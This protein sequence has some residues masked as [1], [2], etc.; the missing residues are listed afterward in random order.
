MRDPQ[1]ALQALAEECLVRVGHDL[2]G[3]PRSGGSG[4]WV[5][6][7]TVLTCAHVVPEGMNATVDLIWQGHRVRGVVVE[8]AGT[9]A[10]IWTYP[11]LAV[12]R[13][14]DTV[15]QHPCVWLAETQP[16]MEAALLVIGHSDPL[17][18]GFQPTSVQGHLRGKVA[19]G[20]GWLWQF[21]SN[22]MRSGM[23]GGPI[24][25]LAAGAVCAL[26]KTTLGEETDR[27]GYVVPLSA[28]NRLSPAARARIL[29]ASDRYHR[30]DQRWVK[31]RSRLPHP[32]D[33]APTML[34][35]EEEVE[36]FGILAEVE[37]PIEELGELYARCTANTRSSSVRLDCLRDVAVALID[38]GEIFPLFQ[39]CEAFA[40]NTDLRDWATALAGRCQAT[41]E[42]R[43]IRSSPARG[44]NGVAVTVEIAPGFTRVDLYRVSVT[45]HHPGGQS[46]LIYCDD[47]AR[48]TLA[49]AKE[50][51]LAELRLALSW[52]RSDAEVEFAVPAGLFDEPFEELSPIRP[53]TNLGRSFRVVLRDVE[54]QSDPFTREEWTRRWRSLAGGSAGLHWMSCLDDRTVT[55][56]AADLERSSDVALLMLSRRPSSCVAISDLVKV[57]LEFGVPALAWRR[58]TCYEHDQGAAIDTCSGGDFRL[59][60][61]PIL[62]KRSLSSLPATVQEIRQETARQEPDPEFDA[63]RNMV[64]VWDNPDRL[65]QQ[66]PLSEPTIRQREETL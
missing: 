64:L 15:P 41:T 4:V 54:R 61:E 46:R 27:G 55:E 19:F 58:D 56:F 51:I 42:L 12:I 14:S 16:P 52:L 18:E 23:S 8:H 35:Y 24:L 3:A 53:Y 20:D 30:S 32:P 6:P 49:E 11:D 5:S 1:L 31:L 25:D 48:H 40:T 34:T 29:T 50:L 39:L 45:V 9:W 47:D 38:N 37:V 57:A 10:S 62:E 33:D 60:I 66:L 44:P 2:V 22:E 63:C 7:D 36:L 59:G 28:L 17:N 65:A 21:K 43:N 13:T 26:A